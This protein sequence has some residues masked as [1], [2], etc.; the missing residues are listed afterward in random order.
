M[1]K[2]IE[3]KT[4]HI[5]TDYEECGALASRET[6]LLNGRQNANFPS[7]CWGIGLNRKKAK[8]TFCFKKLLQRNTFH[9]IPSGHG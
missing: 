9:C 7:L 5:N 1:I 3:T 4:F 8:T 6:Y 2:T